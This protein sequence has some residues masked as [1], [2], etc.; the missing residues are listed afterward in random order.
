MTNPDQMT[1]QESVDTAWG[2]GPGTAQGNVVGHVERAYPRAW[3]RRPG[4]PGL[5]QPQIVNQFTAWVQDPANRPALLGIG[6]LLGLF[7]FA[8]QTRGRGRKLKMPKL[9]R[10]RRA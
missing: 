8:G 5:G 6:A 9:F 1:G 3:N 4:Y 7:L 2:Q 10:R